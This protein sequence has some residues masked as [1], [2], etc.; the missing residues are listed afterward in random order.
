[1]ANEFKWWLADAHMLEYSLC[2]FLCFLFIYLFIIFKKILDLYSYKEG[3]TK[4]CDISNKHFE[5][6]LS[7]KMIFTT[8]GG[9]YCD[10]KT[11]S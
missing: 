4:R 3:A 8:F 10:D 2:L 9:I 1:M 6:F 11:V 7:I 5:L